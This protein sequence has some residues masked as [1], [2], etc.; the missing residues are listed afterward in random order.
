MEGL[1]TTGE[2]NGCNLHI[3]H[4]L[5]RRRL[6]NGGRLDQ[7]RRAEAI[8]KL[9]PDYRQRAIGMWTV[10]VKPN[11]GFTRPPKSIGLPIVQATA[12]R[13]PDGE[14]FFGVFPV[15]LKG[16]LPLGHFHP[17]WPHQQGER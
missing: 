12:G 6:E 17:C 14:F 2:A 4:P 13:G 3:R 8:G 11:A 15:L 1:G 7:Q 9:V 16:G 5:G 10:Q